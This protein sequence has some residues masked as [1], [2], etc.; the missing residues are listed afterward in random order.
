[1]TLLTLPSLCAAG[2]LSLLPCWRAG[3]GRPKPPRSSK[4]AARSA[5]AAD[6][7]S[8]SP[9]FPRLAGQHAGYIERQLRDYK[10]GKRKSRA[11]SAIIEDVSEGPT[12]RRW[13][14]IS[15]A[16]PR[17][18]TRSKTPSWP[19]VGRY[20][21][22][23]GNPYSGVPACSACHGE[24]GAR[25]GCA[26]APGRP[27]HRYVERQLQAF[28]KRERTNDNAV[29]HGVAS[30][31]TELEVRRLQPTWRAK[32][33][34]SAAVVRPGRPPMLT[35]PLYLLDP[36][37]PAARACQ[38]CGMRGVACLACWASHAGRCA[39]PHHAHR[40][41]RA[42]RAAVRRPGRRSRL[43]AA[44]EGFVRFERA[45]AGGDR[46]IIRL[47]GS[48]DLLGQELLLQRPH[49]D[50]AIACTPATLCRIP[51]NLVLRLGHCTPPCCA[52]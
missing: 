12:S 24:N 14:P 25:H 48:G 44:F 26:A 16:A 20:L 5:T 29:M 36:K 31:L 27:A 9:A 33:E 17:T 1:M 18:P 2:L 19:W 47:A 46:R 7:E 30:K 11:M 10:S 23:R 13:G 50:D 41:A 42:R 8:A 35:T 40:T 49:Q 39:Q 38:R 51:V 22:T 15:K 37:D 45:T 52:S 21:F 28:D 32:V 3:P 6:G 34:L 43:H 4:R